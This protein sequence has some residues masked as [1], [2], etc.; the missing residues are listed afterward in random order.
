[1]EIEEGPFKSF[2]KF[3]V[4]FSNGPSIVYDKN[5]PFM[6]WRPINDLKV[7]GF[8]KTLFP[9]V[10]GVYY[11]PK[12]PQ[13]DQ[14]D[15]RKLLYAMENRI[16]PSSGNIETYDKEL[17]KI[18]MPDSYCP[19]LQPCPYNWCKCKLGL[20]TTKFRLPRFTFDPSLKK[21]LLYTIIGLVLL[22]FLWL[23]FSTSVDPDPS[24]FVLDYGDGI[25]CPIT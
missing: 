2:Y 10:Q 17:L 11:I 15:L 25:E 20:P 18:S 19:D 22:L 7:G 24:S 14:I 12:S 9:Y 5:Q 16:V 3:N 13:M 8:N 1:M 21:M 4:N 6:Q 23:M